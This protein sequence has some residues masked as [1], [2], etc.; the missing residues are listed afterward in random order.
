M[1]ST[2]IKSKPAT[3]NPTPDAPE[4]DKQRRAIQRVQQAPADDTTTPWPVAGFAIFIPERQMYLGDTGDGPGL[5]DS[6]IS[7]YLR[8]SDAE[9]LIAENREPAGETGIIVPVRIDP[10]ANAKPTS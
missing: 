4:A 5:R 2:R 7:V 10:C 1:T 3:A 9:A 6:M 8:R